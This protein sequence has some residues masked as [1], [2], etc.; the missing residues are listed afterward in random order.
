[1]NER[2]S[3]WLFLDGAA[4]FSFSMLVSLI[5]QRNDIFA[6]WWGFHFVKELTHQNDG[7]MA[8]TL[9]LLFPTTAVMY[10]GINMFFAAKEAVERKAR[11]RD[12]RMREEGRARGRE[13]GIE[14]GREQGVREILNALERRGVELPPDVVDECLNGSHPKMDR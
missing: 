2:P 11:A 3:L 14:A 1:M 10:G 7:L 9:L 6:E 13:E 5:L 12:E 8:S 4:A